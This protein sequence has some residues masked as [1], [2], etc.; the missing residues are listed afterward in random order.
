MLERAL[1]FFGRGDL[2]GAEVL[3]NHL[4]EQQPASEVA[5]LQGQVLRAAGRWADA[6]AWFERALEANLAVPS[7]ESPSARSSASG[8]R[9]RRP[10]PASSRC[11]CRPGW[12]WPLRRSSPCGCWSW[13]W[14]TPSWSSPMTP[15]PRW[16]RR[17]SPIR[18]WWRPAGPSHLL[19]SRAGQLGEAVCHHQV[20]ARLQ[21]EPL[22][23]R[24]NVSECLQGAGDPVGALTA[25]E[26]L[27]Q[28]FGPDTRITSSFLFVASVAGRRAGCSAG[29]RWQKP[30]GG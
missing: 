1:Q 9:T 21:T 7:H 17:S 14:P 8:A 23:A 6:I 25:L 12:H 28:E 11:C 10:G 30:T 18:R 27:L 3:L 5:A 2:A 22:V 26:G 29:G 19:L 16:K 20:L 4:W 24:L 13:A 15:S